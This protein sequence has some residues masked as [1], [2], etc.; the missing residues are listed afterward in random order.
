MQI[1]YL[2]EEKNSDTIASVRCRTIIPD[3]LETPNTNEFKQ[4][5]SNRFRGFSKPDG[6]SFFEQDG[7]IAIYCFVTRE[8]KFLCPSTKAA[9]E[10]LNSFSNAALDWHWLNRE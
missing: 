2:T 1:N 7:T 6:I 3:D 5:L 9:E 4:F 10:F 8:M